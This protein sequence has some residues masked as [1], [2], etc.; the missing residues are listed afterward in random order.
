M[1]CYHFIIHTRNQ[2]NPVHPEALL[3]HPCH[4]LIHCSELLYTCNHSVSV[5]SLLY[6]QFRSHRFQQVRSELRMV[7]HGRM[8]YMYW[9][10]HKQTLRQTIMLCCRHQI[11]VRS[12]SGFLRRWHPTYSYFRLL[13][14]F[15]YSG[16]IRSSVVL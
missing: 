12:R 6:K 9:T 3:L 5:S 2:D 8:Y 7:L 15:W 11:Q 16:Y 1:N 13:S 4:P 10:H 14:A